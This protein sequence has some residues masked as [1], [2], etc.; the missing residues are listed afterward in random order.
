MSALV[1]AVLNQLYE[2]TIPHFFQNSNLENNCN[3]LLGNKVQSSG[4]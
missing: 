4:R 1:K 2:E 3:K